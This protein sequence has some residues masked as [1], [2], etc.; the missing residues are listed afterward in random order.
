M[1]CTISRS[2]ARAVQKA[3]LSRLPPF[4]KAPTTRVE[5][6]TGPGGPIEKLPKPM[7]TPSI[8]IRIQR[9]RIRSVIVADGWLF[10]LKGETARSIR[11][12]GR[13]AQSV[14]PLKVKRW[15]PAARSQL[16]SKY[17]KC[18][19]F[20]DI[21]TPHICWSNVGVL[22]SDRQLQIARVDAGGRR[23]CH[24]SAL[25]AFGQREGDRLS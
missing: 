21:V 8:N 12:I 25:R 5:K 3:K 24:A 1:A 7:G 19:D 14:T 15:T 20:N 16:R 23:R 11:L 4:P 18:T 6:K 22:A 9:L 10:D 13:P 2:N 17:R